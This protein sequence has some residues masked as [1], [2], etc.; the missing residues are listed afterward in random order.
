MENS[1][2]KSEKNILQT[3]QLIFYTQ[4]VTKYLIYGYFYF[5]ILF[6][7]FDIAPIVMAKWNG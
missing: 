2:L 1:L 4:Q 6:C 5:L 3:S 7:L